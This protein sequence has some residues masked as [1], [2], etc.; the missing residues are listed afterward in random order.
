VFPTWLDFFIARVLGDELAAAGFDV[1]RL[2]DSL[3]ARTIHALLTDPNSFTTSPSTQQPI[4]C[5]NYAVLDPD[6]SCTQAI[7]ASMIDAMTYLES[8]QGFATADLA[9]WRWGTLHRRFTAGRAERPGRADRAEDVDP[10]GSELARSRGDAAAVRLIADARASGVAVRW[11]LPDGA[12]G[13]AIDGAIGGAR[14][15]RSPTHDRDRRDRDLA[16]AYVDAPFTV[17][18]IAAAGAS[19]WVFH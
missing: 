5:D 19:R 14:R 17:A 2:D 7:L 15:E 13:G 3:L 1:W 8:P 4:L 6:G 11:A 18:Q 10:A 12:I 9:A 16:G